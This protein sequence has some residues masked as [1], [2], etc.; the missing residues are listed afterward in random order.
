MRGALRSC[1]DDINSKHGE[2]G[3]TALHFA[4]DGGH[5]EVVQLILED[6]R[7]EVNAKDVE[8]YT[9]LHFAA[10]K[11]HRG[12]VQLLLE[13]E[14]VEVNSKTERGFTPLYLAAREGH[15]GTVKLLL[16]HDLDI[17]FLFLKP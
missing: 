16:E 4:A 8:G 15:S 12:T 10:T 14:R 3:E 7:A 5:K 2:C 6:E 17:W 9:P 11:G 13:H 1:N